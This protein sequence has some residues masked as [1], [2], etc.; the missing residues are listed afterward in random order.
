SK[1]ENNIIW[2]EKSMQDIWNI[3]KNSVQLPKRQAAFSLNRIGM[4]KDII[5]LFILI[6]LASVPELITQ[7]KTNQT[8][9]SLYMQSLFYVI[10]LFIFYYLIFISV[11]FTILSFI[12]YLATWIAHM[13]SRKLRYSILWKT[14]ACASTIPLLIFTISSFFYTITLYFFFVLVLFQ[15]IVLIQTIFLYPKRNVKR[16]KRL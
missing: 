14:T 15:L 1:Y 4:D 6:A 13:A 12:S 11:V 5:F 7:L 8:S 16:S 3:F 10:F 9:S 2:W